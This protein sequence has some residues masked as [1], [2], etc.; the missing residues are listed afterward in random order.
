VIGSGPSEETAKNDAT[1][2]MLLKI[3]KE[4]DEGRTLN[5]VPRKKLD[6]CCKWLV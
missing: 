5:G 6:A 3:K 1:L 4:I 2:K